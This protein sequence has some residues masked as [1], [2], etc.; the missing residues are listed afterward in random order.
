M[1]VPVAAADVSRAIYAAL[2][3]AIGTTWG[4]GVGGLTFGIPFVPANYAILQASGNV[5]T[6]SIGSVISHVHG[7]SLF[8]PGASF[9][10]AV[11]AGAVHTQSNT[12]AAGGA[13]NLA[14]GVRFLLC[15]QYQ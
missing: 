10:L 7:N 1:A 5:G 3:A 14:A 4:V 6:I 15:L 9:T 2:F 11:T 12:D 8:Q 13:A